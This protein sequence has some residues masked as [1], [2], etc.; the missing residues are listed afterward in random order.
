[1]RLRE[2]ASEGKKVGC[3]ERYAVHC[4]FVKASEGR[5]RSGEYVEVRLG[6]V[7]RRESN[8]VGG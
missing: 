4:E 5:S 3:R 7:E 8:E 1:M 2:E 6:A